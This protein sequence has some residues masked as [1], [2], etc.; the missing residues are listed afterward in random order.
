MKANREMPRLC[1]LSAYR[2]SPSVNAAMKM[3][4][5]TCDVF[6]NMVND[7]IKIFSC[8]MASR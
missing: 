7:E 1:R 6:T 2:Y 3:V 4:N 8:D 5:G